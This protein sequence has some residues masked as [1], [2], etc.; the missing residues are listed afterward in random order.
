MLD[1]LQLLSSMH[2]W[3]HGLMGSTTHEDLGHC[4]LLA[5][6]VWCALKRSGCTSLYSF[7]RASLTSLL[8]VV[9]AAPDVL[10]G[11]PTP[12]RSVNAWAVEG[13]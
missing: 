11:P 4:R 5:F 3:A 13:R 2:A 10:N 12:A 6:A 7:L 1:R 9:P 8:P